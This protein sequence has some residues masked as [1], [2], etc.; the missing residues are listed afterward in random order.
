MK[1][2]AATALLAIGATAIAAGT[3][4]GSPAPADEAFKPMLVQ[5]GSENG[6]NYSAELASDTRSLAA[7]T[8]NGKFGLTADAVTLSDDKG[9][10]VATFPLAYQIADK[11]VTLTPAIGED[12][13]KVELTNGAAA[14][15]APAKVISYYS[16]NLRLQRAGQSAGIGAL[17]GAL[18]G[19][20]LLIGIIPGAV[21]GALLGA[22]VGYT[23]PV[24]EAPP[25]PAPAPAPAG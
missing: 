22:I 9:A 8:A 11:T 24:E 20:P 14:T 16:D 18:L 13:H 19:L 2:Y 3:A 25:A 4:Q 1:K 6:V 15:D 7:T 5:Q 17:I 21:F 23:M 12:G 10:V